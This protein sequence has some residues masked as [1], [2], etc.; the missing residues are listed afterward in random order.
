MRTYYIARGLFQ[1]KSFLNLKSYLN[2]VK[3]KLVD[4]KAVLFFF[5]FNFIFKLY[6]IVLVMPNIK[7]NPPQ[8]YPSSPSR[9]PLPSPS[10]SH[11]SESSQCTSPEYPVSCIKP[12]LVIYFT[13][14]NIHVSAVLKD[15]FDLLQYC[16]CFVF[17]FFWV[18]RH[19]E[20]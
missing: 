13:H 14:D 10:S 3:K 7:M 16:F 1:K 9:T 5:K 8:V 11:S 15:L 2:L 17:W 20:S 18:V 6:N 12:G 19:V 4:H